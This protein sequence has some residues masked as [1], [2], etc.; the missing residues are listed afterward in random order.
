M[1]VKLTFEH[2]RDYALPQRRIT[3]E[4]YLENLP[5]KLAGTAEADYSIAYWQGYRDAI[6]SVEQLIK[7]NAA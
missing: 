4:R 5:G 6:K 1:K 7:D 2:I 3:A